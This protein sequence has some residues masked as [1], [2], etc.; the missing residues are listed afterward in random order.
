MS[1][2]KVSSQSRRRFL[3]YS[4]VGTM[5]SALLDGC[6]RSHTPQP[7][8]KPDKT[9]PALFSPKGDGYNLLF[10]FTDQERY[11]PQWPPGL[12]LPAHERLQKTGITFHN[13]YTS[14]V[15]CT[16]SR[17]VLL[18]GLQT[19]IN[20]MFENTNVPYVPNLSP[21]IPTFGHLLRKAGYY[22]AYK[23]KW[24]LSR[25]FDIKDKY[26]N[27]TEA[28]EA[29]GFA[30]YFDPGDIVGHTLGGYLN[31]HLIA[32]SAIRWLRNRGKPLSA[33]GKPWSLT[34]SL[35]N[36]HDVMYFNTDAQDEQR[37]DTGKLAMQAARAPDH[38]PIK[39]SPCQLS[40]LL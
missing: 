26:P 32:G 2:P 3:Q 28:M 20:G 24:H 22:T 13:H 19:P 25:A 18:T 10:V 29:Y 9:S 34:V 23:G 7:H 40:H 37:Q 17:S 6:L 11:F 1:N 5:G 14:A 16:S 36:P 38:E 8:A 35:V 15:M 27:L 21:D 39:P 31:D 30:D 4:L 12:S 33:E